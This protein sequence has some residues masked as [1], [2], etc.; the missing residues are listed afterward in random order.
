METYRLKSKLVENNKEFIIQTSNDSD[1]GLVSTVVYVDGDPT[2]TVQSLHP[3]DVSS[4]EVLALVKT[5]HEEMKKEVETLLEAYRV[6]RSDGDSLKLHHL[7]MAFY[8]K[9]FYNEARELFEHAVRL[10]PQMHQT[11]NQLGLTYQALGQLP[12]A[13]QAA[14]TAV[15]AQPGFAD[16]RNNLGAAFLAVCSYKRAVIELEEA[17]R[18][19]LYYSEA[20]FNLGLALIRN[21]LG[22]DDT[23][24]FENVL[25]KS[26]DYFKRAALIQPDHETDAFRRGLEA[27]AESDLQSAN[28]LLTSVQQTR[29]ERHR[30][31]FTTF[32]M[33]YVMYPEWVSEE[34]VV[35]RIAFLQGELDKNPSYV[36]LYSELGR[37]YFE[38][39]RLA[40]QK[41][42]EQYRRVVEMNPSLSKV[43][44]DLDETTSQ[45]QEICS[46]LSRIMRRS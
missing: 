13:T 10:D 16:Y 19:N 44:S 6:V 3:S 32:Y 34:A 5:K 11:Y 46:L 27:I 18:I 22:G 14:S 9:Q 33:R 20:Y 41:G 30:Q 15:E 36:D 24:L 8:Y 42:L 38:Q 25:T 31:D 35:D 23:S 37:C 1:P 21:A 45:Y 12:E 26:T 17:I 40:W 28:A 4:E 43:A 7:G 39:S 2:G 29:K